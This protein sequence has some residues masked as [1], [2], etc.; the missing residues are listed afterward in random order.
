MKNCDQF[1]F[2]HLFAIDKAH[3]IFFKS[4]LNSSSKSF[5]QIDFH[6]AQVAVGSHH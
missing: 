2:G 3:L 5:P 4:E 6:Q 1:V